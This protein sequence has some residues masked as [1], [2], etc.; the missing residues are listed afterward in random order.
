MKGKR[1]W[2]T[3]RLWMIRSSG[4]RADY[5]RKHSIY[6]G[7]GENVT[8]MDR[9][10]PLY[11]ELICFHNNIRVA[12]KVSFITHDITDR[13]L[14][15]YAED[16]DIHFQ[17]IVGCIEVMDNVFIG[18]NTTIL[19]NVRIGPNAIIAAGS[20]VNRDVPPNSIAGGVPAKVIGDF[21]DYVEKRKALMYPPEI[22]P[23]HQSVSERL[24]KYLWEN[25]NDN[26]KQ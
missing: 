16:M 25:F 21:N 19:S 14:N 3:L 11:S 20:L 4:A 24:A 12:S 9:K 17:E 5:A 7:M 23:A 8:I 1:M 18:S 6:A 26:K 10:V 13:M 2:H 22:A 15:Q